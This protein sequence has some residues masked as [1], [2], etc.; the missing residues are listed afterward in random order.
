M[1]TSYL[2]E[3]DDQE[4]PITEPVNTCSINSEELRKFLET[5]LCLPDW[6]CNGQGIERTVKKVSEASSKVAG[7]EK[8]DGWIRAGDNSRKRLPKME[9]KKD[10]KSLLFT[11]KF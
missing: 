3:H 2:F 8:R 11:E 9:S 10:Y 6:P 7:F 1:K 5:P 4:T